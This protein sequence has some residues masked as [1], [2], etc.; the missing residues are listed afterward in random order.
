M[1][2]PHPSRPIPRPLP[3][4]AAALLALAFASTAGAETVSMPEGQ[5]PAQVRSY[6]TPERMQS[7]QPLQVPAF[8]GAA[9]LPSPGYARARRSRGRV[10]RIHATRGELADFQPG[11]ETTFPNLVHGKVFFTLPSLGDFACSGTLIASR[12][13][14]VVFTAGH[15][16]YDPDTAQAATNWVFVPGY[17]DGSEPLGEFPAAT[18]LTSDEWVAGGDTNFDVAVAELANPLEDL[19]GARGIAFN[20]APNTDYEI[21]G[22]PGEPDPPYDGQRLIECDA[23]FYGLELAPSHPFSIVAYPCNMT[24][25]A[26]GGG[27]VDPAG[28]VVSLSSHVYSDPALDDQIAGPFFGDEIKKLYNAAGGSAECPPARHA[29]KS[30]R[31]RLRNA[32]RQVKRAHRRAA[33]RG[34]RRA[35]RRLHRARRSLGRAQSR[36]DSV[37]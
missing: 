12:L 7:A 27:W 20:K 5:D 37:C 1:R 2:A 9:V 25:G 11:A 23:P 31:K 16:A 14:N 29:V 22:Y 8:S 34:S 26:S 13:H 3:A 6:W 17:R 33:R 21:F 24:H 19:I 32:R 10:V 30:A 36:R 28:E 18:L 35:R 15:C 4:I